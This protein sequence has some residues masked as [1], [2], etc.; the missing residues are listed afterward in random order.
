MRIRDIF[1]NKTTRRTQPMHSDW[2]TG[3]STREWADLPT[4]HPRRE[5]DAIR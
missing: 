1:K 5:R 2:T 4:H 3:W